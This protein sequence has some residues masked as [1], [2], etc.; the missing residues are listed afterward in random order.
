M[1]RNRKQSSD[2]FDGMHL[3]IP[4]PNAVHCRLRYSMRVGH[5]KKQQGTAE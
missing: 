3:R 1:I 2:P 4:L 5:G